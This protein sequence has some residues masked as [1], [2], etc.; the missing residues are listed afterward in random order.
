MKLLQWKNIEPEQEVV[1]VR[2]KI[3]GSVIFWELED[4]ETVEDVEE[5]RSSED[6]DVIGKFKAEEIAL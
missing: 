1:L 3:T 5:K 4:G 2:E 6:A